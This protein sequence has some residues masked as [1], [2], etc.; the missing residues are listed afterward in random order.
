MTPEAALS[1]SLRK[2]GGPAFELKY[3]LTLDEAAQAEEWAR[4]ALAP[5]PHG[6]DGAYRTLSLYCDTPARDVFHRSRG[7]RRSKY[8]IRRYEQGGFLHLERKTRRGD[9]VSK[10]RSVL[11][12]D[13]LPLVESA[14]PEPEWDWGWFLRQVR[15]RDLSPAA[16]LG[17]ARTAF[18]GGCPEGPMRLTIDRGLRGEPAAGWDVGPLRDPRPLLEGKAVLELKYADAL[19]GPF[20]RLLEI[21]P[22][23]RPGGASKYR[24]CLRAWG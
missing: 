11:A 24:L 22:P 12:L 14:D 2:G 10:K 9:R 7:Y 3:V 19:P 4:S 20:R 15:F 6:K 8:R 5:D 1:P 23:N 18:V 16:R 17:Y 13:H 21:L